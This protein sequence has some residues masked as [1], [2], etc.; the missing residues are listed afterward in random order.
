MRPLQ[1]VVLDEVAEARVLLVADRRL[2]RDRL[3][4]DLQDLLDA[5]RRDLHLE[6]DLL[7]R[8]VALQLLG[9]LAADADELVD[10][11]DHV[12]RHADRAGLVGDAAGDRLPDP[13][14]R[15][16][17]E[18]VAAAPVELLDGA[19]QAEVALLDQVEE[20]H[21]RGRRSASRPTPRAAGW[22]RSAPAWPP[23]RRARCASRGR[24]PPPPVSSGT[25]PISRRYARTGS[26]SRWR[27]ADV[28]GRAGDGSSASPRRPRLPLPRR[29]RRT[30]S[31]RGRLL[32]RLF[33]I[34]RIDA[35]GCFGVIEAVGLHGT[36]RWQ[37]LRTW[38]RKRGLLSLQPVER[39]LLLSGVF[40]CFGCAFSSAMAS[41]IPRYVRRAEVLD[42]APRL[43][44]SVVAR[45]R[46]SAA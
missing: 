44:A 40:G 46:S 39:D 26:W 11:L 7:V 13:P 20:Q 30:R 15:V 36:P 31:P 29:R 27:T 42:V 35:C 8:R 3:L 4:R 5:L 43:G 34:D 17:R 41:S 21:A 9:E 37:H 33:G 45:R 1:L 25:L 19:H 38:S 22:P 18:L 14:R 23:G 28:D 12:H 10:R 16:G 2:E 6:R 32:Q 24:S